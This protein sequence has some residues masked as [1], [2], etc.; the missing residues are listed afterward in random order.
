MPQHP[1]VVVD[2][3]SKAYKRRR[4]RRALADVIVRLATRTHEE[5]PLRWVLRDVSFTLGAGESL[6]VVG[7]NG[8][9]KST[10]LKIVAGIARP[11]AGLVRVSARVSAQFALGAGFNMS[12]TGVENA[13]LQGTVLGLTNREVRR[14]L[15]AIEA[16]A[17][18]DEAMHRPVWSYSTGMVTR[19][20]FAVAAHAPGDL[21][22]FDEALG[23]GDAGFR[24]RCGRVLRDARANGRSLIVVSHS[25]DAIRS[26]CDRAIWLDHG[27]VRAAGPADAI[28]DEYT[29]SVVAE[30]VAAR[31]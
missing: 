20:A 11:T 3:V 26:L 30:T 25:A 13:Y 6:G 21:M 17:D 8:A 9:G 29:R 12:L 10:L 24:E 7:R 27:K 4:H 19:L 15:P 22:L 18:L 23:A 2:R 31:E 5:S 16:F 14:L 28:V 1:L